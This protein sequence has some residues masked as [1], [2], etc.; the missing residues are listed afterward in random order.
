M[1]SLLY[2]DKKFRTW[3]IDRLAEALCEEWRVLKPELTIGKKTAYGYRATRIS[4]SGEVRVTI[5][6]SNSK[7]LDAGYVSPLFNLSLSPD[8]DDRSFHVLNTFQFM[9]FMELFPELSDRKTLFVIGKNEPWANSH[10]ERS[11]QLGLLMVEILLNFNT[12][13]DFLT[14]NTYEIS[15]ELLDTRKLLA[16]QYLNR[17]KAYRL[18]ENYGHPER[19]E[20]AINA[21]RGSAKVNDVA[22]Q[23]LDKLCVTK[24][25]GSATWLY[26]PE[27]IE[28]LCK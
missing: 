19:L 5:D 4:F 8:P 25:P 1:N 2:K 11:A 21:I 18:A 20:E 16:G 9:D 27:M 10:F 15:G 14:N 13:F 17:V 3:N 6:M 22:R 12:C 7:V 23:N 26:T 24:S 28:R